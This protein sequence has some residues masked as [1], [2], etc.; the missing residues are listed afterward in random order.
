MNKSFLALIVLAIASYC[1]SNKSTIEHGN[2]YSLEPIPFKLEE[3]GKWGFIDFEGNIII[4][5]KYKNKPSYFQEGYAIISDDTAYYFINIKG[6]TIGSYYRSAQFFREGVALIKDSKK[7]LYFIDTTGAKL[8]KVD[9]IAN[10]DLSECSSFKD[11]RA[12]IRTVYNKYGYIDMNGKLVIETKYSKAS[13]FSEGLAYVELIKEEEEETDKENTEKFF[14][15]TNGDLVFKLNP[16]IEWIHNFNEGLVAFKDSSGCGFMNKK[17]EI[18]ISQNK[19][20][21]DLTNFINGYAAYQCG[22]DWG[23]IDS[24]GTK[25]LSSV[26]ERPP[27]FYQGQAI[28]KENDKYGVIN[29][30]GE[31]V[32]DCSY[33]H[34]A[35]P[36]FNDRYFAKDGKFYIM[37]DPTGNR[38]GD[39]E[40]LRIDL[41]SLLRFSFIPGYI[42]VGQNLGI[43]LSN[44][45]SD[46]QESED[47]YDN[48]NAE[49]TKLYSN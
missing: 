43:S 46:S 1:C 11:G 47:F 23:V 2:S 4:E 17:G 34:I 26:Y 48:V 31:K 49:L 15:D 3:F 45:E 16:E 9:T 7:E 42:V 8:F 29:L 14:I 28:I 22:G 20:W 44:L 25:V 24:T 32:I 41:V 38:L 35:Y 30:K 19:K 18:V 12:L 13:E 33:Y 5:P 21:Q 40:F 37:I 36:L 39:L 6:D 27:S 10:D